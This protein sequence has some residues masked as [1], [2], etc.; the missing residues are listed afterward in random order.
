M[1]GGPDM[2]LD[3][4]PA[5][6]DHMSLSRQIYQHTVT[7]MKTESVILSQTFIKK[8]CGIVYDFFKN[9]LLVKFCSFMGIY[10]MNYIYMYFLVLFWTITLNFNELLLTHCEFE[11]VQAYIHDVYM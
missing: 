2:L 7:N 8:E 4:N 5:Y 10:N 11:L 1:I 3:T 6:V 9:F